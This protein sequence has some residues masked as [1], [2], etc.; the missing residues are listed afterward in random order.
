[1]KNYV[2]QDNNIYSHVG[3]SDITGALNNGS[4]TLLDSLLKNAKENPNYL[5][6]GRIIDGLIEYKSL[7]DL[8][9][10]IKKVGSFLETIVEENEIVGIYSSNRIEWIVSEYACYISNII[11]CPLHVTFSPASL[12]H[13]INETEMKT[14]FATTD[15]IEFLIEKVLSKNDKT[16]KN[17]I[18]MDSDSV[19]KSLCQDKG[20][21]VYDFDEILN[22]NN[23]CLT[24]KAPKSEDLATICYTSGTT[25]SPKGAM[26]THKNFISALEGFKI[27]S[28]KYD[29]FNISSKDV[30]ISFL[31]LAHVF[32]RIVF[33]IAFTSGAKIV[34]SR[35]DVKLLKEDFKLIKPT[36]ITVVPRVLTVFHNKIVESV[37]ALSP[38]KKMLFNFA[39]NW[40]LFW[41]KFGFRKS[42]LFDRLIF[43]KIS[44]EF[45]GMISG[46]L[47]GGAAINSQI[48]DYLQCVLSANI[49]QGYGQTE[50]LGA[51]IVS[52]VNMNDSSSVGIP[53][54]STQI[55][56]VSDPGIKQPNMHVFLKG[57]SISKGY[58]K[59]DDLTRSTFDKDGWIITGDIGKFENGK[60]YISGRS[61][62]FFKTSFGE[63][64]LPENVENELGGGV[65]Q[66]LFITN[67]ID[68]DYL[69]AVVHCSD[70]KLSVQDVA[71]IIKQKGQ[72]A[73]AQNRMC[74]YEIPTHFFLID[75]PF[76]Y[77]DNGDLMTPSMKKKRN[78]IRNYFRN[79]IEVAFKTKY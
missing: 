13:I 36:F 70:S 15:K 52:P 5:V 45:G 49:F 67:S 14:I 8:E 17:I 7:S 71:E 43:S 63:Y 22:N 4:T 59:R 64:I 48:I 16:V 35:G 57:P 29:I 53:F 20:F 10:M 37:D 74:R 39:L 33:L 32:E 18:L 28:E 78:L 23:I 79:E 3:L 44:D 11:N 31:P 41:L 25:G 19:K 21:N 42:W 6:L 26:L 68:S 69:L 51:N 55:K 24:R 76:N 61:K 75:H 27:G 66:D 38:L 40:K 73:V 34:F 2:I 65:I 50:G 30:Y 9:K 46:A 1:M 56:L 72:Q 58:Y 54:I 60:F 77:Y 12:E 62:E 47:C